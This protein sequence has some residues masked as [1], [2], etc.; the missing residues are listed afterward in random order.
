VPQIGGRV[1]HYGIDGRNF[2]FIG[3]NE[4]GVVPEEGSKTIYRHFG[5]HYAQ[6][7]PEQK[8]H[9]VRGSAPAAHFMG[10]YE[11]EAA[12]SQGGR[13]A[14]TMRG[15]VD[16]ASRTHF[17]R[18]VELLPGSTRL[19][20]TDTL[21]NA[22][23]APQEWG[24]HDILQLKGTEAADGIVGERD[25][26]R[27][28]IRLYAPLNPES[29]L[30][31]GGCQ[32]VAD[33]SASRKGSRQWS[34]R[35]LPG[36]LVLGY[37]GLFGKLLVDPAL[38]WVAFVDERAGLVFVQTCSAPR[39]AIVAAGA[40]LRSHPLVEVQSFA[41][42]V[43]LGP[44]Q[45]TQL[46]QEW[47]AAR[48]PAPIVDVTAAGVVSA[49]LSLLSGG[50]DTWVAGTFGVFHVGSA[51]VVFRNSR[52]EELRRVD[53]GAV[54]PLRAIELNAPVTVPPGT[55]QIVLEV[56]CPTGQPLGHLGRILLDPRQRP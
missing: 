9:A 35:A 2:L 28:R 22:G 50:G 27:G 4:L 48:C 37:R 21:T 16:L 36:M 5:G 3:R 49:P 53:C 15:S 40:P 12:P 11:A 33:A 52:G 17:L 41:P 6:L 8:W 39:K 29:R 20:L 19:R 10:R 1:L 24:I 54:G 23:V 25:R 56:V 51:A 26:A 32:V 42:V 44:G 34:T 14:L 43:R 38:P 18:T 45:S 47:A 55:A 13:A 30:P 7:H 46:V 31:N